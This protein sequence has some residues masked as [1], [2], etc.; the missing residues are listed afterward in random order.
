MPIKLEGDFVS[1]AFAGKCF[2]SG[3]EVRL[4]QYEYTSAKSEPKGLIGKLF[5]K[6]AEP[7]A[8]PFNNA[9]KDA[10][11][12]FSINCSS[13]DS[14]ET[15]FAYAFSAYLCRDCAAILDDPQTG[16]FFDREK[17]ITIEV[18]AIVDEMKS[19]YQAG[20]LSTHDFID[21]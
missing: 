11:H 4:N 6:K 10:S 18:N 14:F 12:Y 21:L 1:D 7:Q 13:Q 8:T 16:Q 3:H 17:L 2:L 9:I 20:E 19:I 5:G 15:L